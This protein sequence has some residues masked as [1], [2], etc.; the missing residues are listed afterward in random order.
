M[1]IWHLNLTRAVLRVDGIP[2]AVRRLAA[3]Q[4]AL[5]ADVDV[6]S[7]GGPAAVTGVR[8]RLARTGDRPEAV[9]FHSVFRPLHALVAR[10]LV[11]LGVPYVVSPHSGYAPESLA[12][13]QLLKR[14][15]TQLV[16]RR[17]VAAA[18]AASCLTEAERDDLRRFSPA[19]R[20][21]A[22]VVPNALDDVGATRAWTP[23]SGGRPQ[24]VTLCR[25]D[26]R[27]KGLD[28]LA[29]LARGCP[30]MD[31]TVYGEQDKNEGF[32][33]DRLRRLAP[34]NFF[35]RPPVFGPDKEVVVAS[36]SVFVLLSRWEGLSMSLVEALGA[37]LPCAVST[38]VGRTLPALGQGAGLVLDD[39]AGA[40]SSQLR[41]LIA[42]R[43]RLVALSA[44]GK[45]YAAATFQPDEVARRT[46]E[47]Y[48]GLTPVPPAQVRSGR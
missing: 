17:F 29:A 11:E 47:C 41:S 30:E 2:T 33:T 34:P 15:Y 22:V 13:R 26:V 4:Q 35:L 1:R 40:A 25:Y 44:A 43:A 42:D 27:Q 45:A 36:A 38:Y 14:P 9:H 5:G 7:G 19:F 12:R 32:L 21:P 3:A 31:F 16:E 23:P 37:G 28:R 10:R 48:R 20:G 18:G 8:D 6:F 39:E 46:L 24:V